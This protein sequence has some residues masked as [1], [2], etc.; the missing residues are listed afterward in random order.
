MSHRREDVGI[1]EMLRTIESRL[2]AL[3]TAQGI[4]QNDVRIGDWLFTVDEQGCVICF[5]IKT[6]QRK[7]SC[8]CL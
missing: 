1:I 6:N 7:S 5:N 8:D 3:E 2:S 4:R